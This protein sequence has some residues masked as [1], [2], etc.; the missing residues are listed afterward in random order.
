[1]PGWDQSL[2]GKEQWQHYLC[3]FLPS[4][5]LNMMKVT[6]HAGQN[7]KRAEQVA[8]VPT[9][10]VV[11]LEKGVNGTSWYLKKDYIWRIDRNEI[12]ASQNLCVEGLET[13][14]CSGSHLMEEK[15]KGRKGT[16]IC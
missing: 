4:Q 9:A 14:T 16:S 11:Y 2:Q 5:C 15:M 10:A 6:K 8:G 7:V 1:M 13:I 3:V 12:T